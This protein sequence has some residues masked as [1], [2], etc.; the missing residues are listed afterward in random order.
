MLATESFCQKYIGE[1]L[2]PALLEVTY[3]RIKVLD[4]LDISNFWC[5]WNK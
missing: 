4:T 1:I 5:L 3:Q 2:E